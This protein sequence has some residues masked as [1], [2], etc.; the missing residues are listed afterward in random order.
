MFAV[1]TN[2][3]KDLA[4]LNAYA[5]AYPQKIAEVEQAR[6][7]I[8]GQYRQRRLDAMWQEW[9]Q[10]NAATQAVAAAFDAFGQTASNALT[11]S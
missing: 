3:Q 1:E 5:V 2:Y 4:A 9:S 6:A 10:Q 7:A 8:E 11:V